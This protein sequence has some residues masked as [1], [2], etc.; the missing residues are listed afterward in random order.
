MIFFLSDKDECEAFDMNS[1]DQQCNNTVGGYD[2]SCVDG[3]ELDAN[4]FTCNGK[5]QLRKACY[6]TLKSFQLRQ[7]TEPSMPLKRCMLQQ[8][9]S[10]SHSLVPQPV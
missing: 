7:L 10:I 2:C 5:L 1:C 8:I 4:G 6:A 3:Y 9:L